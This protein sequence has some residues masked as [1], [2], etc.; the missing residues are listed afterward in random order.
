MLQPMSMHTPLYK[1][2][3]MRVTKKVTAKRKA[4]RKLTIGTRGYVGS[5]EGFQKGSSA[6]A[7]KVF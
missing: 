4:V 5:M 2:F 1:G 6:V 3:C 7:C